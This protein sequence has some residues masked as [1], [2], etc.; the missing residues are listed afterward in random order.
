M[1]KKKTTKKKASKSIDATIA[2]SGKVDA[3]PAAAPT[4]VKE[5]KKSAKK[6]PAPPP[7]TGAGGALPPPSQDEMNSILKY[8]MIPPSE[9]VHFHHVDGQ[10]EL[11]AQQTLA[12]WKALGTGITLPGLSI[13][14][15]SQALATFEAVAPIEQKILPYYERARVTRMKAQSDATGVLYALARAIK[16]AGAADLA[17]TFAALIG[18]IA[19]THSPKK[20]R[21]KKKTT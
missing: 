6:K 21:A 10:F 17:Q 11:I 5:K 9:V 19:A 15:L 13:D 18:W 16:S 2:T 20:P 4:P 8:P 3:A 1:A 14:T 7:T 12:S